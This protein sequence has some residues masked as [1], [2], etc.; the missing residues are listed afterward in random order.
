MTLVIMILALVLGLM[1]ELSLPSLFYPGLARPPILA[2]VVA[3][4]ALNHSVPAMLLAALAGGILID[5]ISALPLGITSLALAA[6]GAV[7]HHY[8]G[9]VF[10]GKLVTNIVFGAMIG[11]SVP[12]IILVLLLFLGQTPYCF[13]LRFL[14][15]ISGTLVYG[16]VSFPVVYA[17]LERLEL[18]TGTGQ[19]NYL[20]HD[21]HS[22]N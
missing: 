2:G 4:Y 10:S 18:L 5:G 20:S 9:T 14:F 11:A 3:Y 1:L 8:R 15:K 12:L 16:A 17:L 22:N 13:Q 21:T 6:V 7:L 19:L